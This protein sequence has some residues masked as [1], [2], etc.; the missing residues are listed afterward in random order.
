MAISAVTVHVNSGAA[1]TSFTSASFTPAANSMLVAFQNARTGASAIPTAPTGTGLTW[2]LV[3]G[4][5]VSAGAGNL[6]SSTYIAEVGSSPSAITATVTSAGAIAVS[7]LIFGFT[8]AST[9]TSNVGVATDTAGDPAPTNSAMAATSLGVALNAQNAGA[10]PTA[11]PSAQGYVSVVNSAPATNIRHTLFTDSA[12]PANAVSWVTTGTDSIG[13]LWEVKEAAAAPAI[14]GTI[15]QT[16]TRAQ[17]LILGT[18]T[19]PSA[20]QASAFQP[21]QAFQIP[22]VIAGVGGYISQI[23]DRATQAAVGTVT[24]APAITGTIAQALSHASQ[25]ASG[26]VFTSMSGTIDQTLTRASQALAGTVTPP[27]AITGTIGQTAPSATQN[28]MGSVAT[29]GAIVGQI[30]QTAIIARQ[31]LAGTVTPAPA[32]TGTIVQTIGVAQ[33]AAI[34]TV[35]A[36]G[37]AKSRSYGVIIG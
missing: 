16:I 32:I 2:T 29:A 1:A 11:S 33:Q 7:L 19:D 27:P 4:T 23:A 18:V 14:T 8:G 26:I 6:K 17:E 5:N 9:D 10:A 20:F 3:P 35:V 30:Q 25:A 36:A 15:A 12:S 31:A 13:I 24:P 37:A 28:A 22:I 21:S 34:G